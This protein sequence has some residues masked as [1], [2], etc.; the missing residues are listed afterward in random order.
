MSSFVLKIIAIICMLIDHTG[1]VFCE[2]LD[3]TTYT[4]LRCIGRI[5]FPIFA[6]LIVEGFFHT[7]NLKKYMLRLGIFAIISEYPYDLMVMKFY[8]T[9]NYMLAQNIF[10][11]LLLGL[12][13][14][15]GYRFI[16]KKYRT[17]LFLSNVFDSL[18]TLAVCFIA[19]VL[20]TDYSLMGILLIASFYLFRGNKGLLLMSGI[21]LFGLVGGGR[22]QLLAILAYIPIFLYNGKKGKSMKY[23][24]YAFYPAHILILFLIRRFF[25]S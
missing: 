8:N 9:S 5:A 6:F 1:V 23:F 2:S 17:E 25:F 20:R 3:P 21:I 24:F 7:S 15:T 19:C 13:L 18:L 10:F 16:E 22:V 4:I 11:T 14:I 12:L